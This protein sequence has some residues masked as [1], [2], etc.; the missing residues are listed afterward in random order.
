MQHT[1][2]EQ[3]TIRLLGN[4]QEDLNLAA[5]IL[6]NEGIVALPTETVYGLA[7]HG[8]S[9]SAMLKIFAA[10]KR[11]FNNPLILHVSNKERARNL[12][13]FS[14]ASQVVLRRF[15]L[16]ARSFWPGP[17]TMI[18]KKASYVP[19]VATGSLPSVAVRVPHN[20]VTLSL[21]ARLDF[22]LAMPSANLSTRPSP[23]CASHVLKTLDG[24]IDAVVDDGHCTVGIESTIVKIDSESVEILRPG[25]I[26]SLML[27]NC[28]NESIKIPH[29][30][31]QDRLESAGQHYL[32]YSPSITAVEMCHVSEAQKYWQSED[33]VLAKKSDFDLLEK[34]YEKRPLSAIN[35]ILSD[36]PKQYA[37]ELYHALYECERS[38]EKRLIIISPST[39]NETW[40]GI[41]DRLQRSAGKK[42]L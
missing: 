7:A 18:A 5:H 23:T 6:R 11:P 24:R 2:S 35:I 3:K 21:M 39:Y 25:A 10:K 41:V 16:L 14:S 4:H 17:L 1:V 12:F 30:H 37:Q 38:P 19:C 20:A 29:F 32:H 31:H 36:E 40:H 33:I 22:P 9:P 26:D 42:V 27:E 13:D 34:S 28:L 15:K 8:F